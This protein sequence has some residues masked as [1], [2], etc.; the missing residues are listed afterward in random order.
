MIKIKHLLLSATAV[1]CC[2]VYISCDHRELS[3]PANV[4]YLRVYLNEEIKNVTYGFYNEA[5]EHPSFNS[6]LNMRAVLA[7]EEMGEIVSEVL[8]RNQGS[9]ERGKYIEGYIGAESGNYNLL[10][11][12]L[13]S[14][15]T[16][17]GYPN[18]Y[19]EMVAYTNP[20]SERVLGYLSQIS[21]KADRESIVD[22]PEHILVARGRN[23]HLSH[24]L[25]AD[26]LKN[27]NGDYFTASSIAKSYYLQLQIKGVEWVKAAAAV[28]SGMAGS[29]KLCEENGMVVSDSVNLFFS[30]QYADKRLRTGEE[31]SIAT[32]YTT[33]ATF[34]KIPDELS[35]LTLNF[36][37]TKSDGST[38][39]ESIDITDV[40]KTPMAIENQWLI[41]DKEIVIT[42][43]TG[44]GGMTPEVEGWQDITADVPM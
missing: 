40:F 37:F 23:L 10:V 3:D 12:Q 16:Q 14:P 17:I 44:S 36:E 18:D 24:Y 42:R 11:Y 13:G 34:G 41:I 22:E 29:S 2:M 15:V 1:I 19:Y 26:T 9:D 6:P 38:Q 21:S 28:L 30:M 32:L 39:V 8:L 43:P 31:S 25:G 27:E 35:V 5:Y 7:S 4:H 33:F 20:V